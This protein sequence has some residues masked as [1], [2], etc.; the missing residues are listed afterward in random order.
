MRRGVARA[1]DVIG[2]VGEGFAFS[3]GG[4]LI[5]GAGLADRVVP[6]IFPGHARLAVYVLPPA[7]LAAD[8]LQS[9][10][11]VIE[12]DEEVVPRSIAHLPFSQEVRS[13]RPRGVAGRAGDGRGR[14]RGEL[15]P[16]NLS[17]IEALPMAI[18]EDNHH[19][20][21]AALGGRG[22]GGKSTGNSET[23]Q[24]CQT[25]NADD[26]A[27]EILLCSQR[28]DNVSGSAASI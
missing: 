2:R 7:V 22:S 11:I 26:C 24:G 19:R 8:G 18:L 25:G 3:V 5:A 20:A 6:A 28:R 27:H 9:V 21:V 23:K 14:G 10:A 15:H 12:G 16:L 1:S 4:L 17:K 13:R